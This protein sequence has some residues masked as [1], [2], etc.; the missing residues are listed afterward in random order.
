MRDHEL[1][2]AVVAMEGRFP[3]AN[4][5]AEL[6]QRLVNADDLVDPITP[7]RFLA[8]GGDPALLD[9]PDLVLAEAPITDID[10]FDHRYFGYS[11]G[12]AALIDPQQRLF[13]EVCVHA[14]E[15]AGLDP[16][17][18]PRI[19]V[20]AGSGQGDYLRKVVQP[21]A[22]PEPESTETFTAAISNLISSLP[23]RVAYCL[24]LRG[25]AVAVQTACSTSLV[26][27]HMACQDLLSM[28]C[29]A[30]LAGG[31]NVNP[32]PGLGHVAVPGGLLSPDGRC[33]SFAA[34]ANGIGS[35]DAVAV[36]VLKRYLDAVE[37]GDTI[38]GVIR[39]SAINN[40]GRDK[41]GFT[42]PSVE[43]QAE[44]IRE[45][46]AMADLDAGSI[47]Y[48]EAHGTGTPTG[49][50][51]EVA[52]LE[53]A[54]GPLPAASC[55]IGSIKSNLGHTD[56]AA[57]VVGLIKAV[58]CVEQGLIPATLHFDEPNP[59]IDF[60]KSPLRVVSATEPWTTRVPRRAGVS[61]FG[62][63]GTNAHL[64]VEQP[65]EA[66]PN[67]PA[68]TDQPALLTVTAPNASS[69]QRRCVQLSTHF[70]GRDVD[71]HHAAAALRSGPTHGRHRRSVPIS[72]N[73]DQPLRQLTQPAAPV[74]D[75]DLWCFPGGGT[76]TAG[77]IDG[78][79]CWEAFGSAFDQAVLAAAVHV[80]L[81]E[82]LAR[83]PRN[84]VEASIGIMAT[85]YAV[86][87]LLTDKVGPPRAVLGHSLGE[88]AAALIAGVLDLPSAM[89]MAA[90]RGHVLDAAGGGTTL[91]GAAAAE[92]KSELPPQLCI[93]ADNGPMSS[94]VS[95]PT[96]I[97]EA[98]TRSVESRWLVRR[99]DVPAAVHHPLLDEHM[100]VLAEALAETRLQA[101]T[102]PEF[103]STVHAD[104]VSDVLTDSTYWLAQM[105]RP[106]RL[107]EAISVARSRGWRGGLDIGPGQS[108]V[109]VAESLDMP[110]IP[111]MPRR[112]DTHG[113]AHAVNTALGR[114]WEA[115]AEL[116]LPVMPPLADAPPYPF[117][118]VS[119]W[120]A[121]PQTE[122][123]VIDGLGSGN[124]SARDLA[125][126]GGPLLVASPGDLPAN[127][128][129]DPTDI[130]DPTSADTE[131]DHADS[132]ALDAHLTAFASQEIARTLRAHVPS[133]ADGMAVEALCAHL[134]VRRPYDRLVQALIR[135]LLIHGDLE[136]LNGD[137]IR[138]TEKRPTRVADGLAADLIAHCARVLPDVVSGRSNGPEVLL[139]GP[140]TQFGAEDERTAKMMGRIT[141]KL[142]ATLDDL[143]G[144]AG[145]AGL[146][147]L[148]IGAGRG[149]LSWPA[150]HALKRHPG[151]TF[152]FTDVG[153]SFVV[154]A[155]ERA[156]AEQLDHMQFAT[157]DAGHSATEQGFVS[158]SQDVVIAFNSLHAVPDASEAIRTCSE[159]LA[160][161]GLLFLVE[162]HTLPGHAV[163]TAGLHPGMWH[164]TDDR[165]GE[166]PILPTAR[167]QELLAKAGC[168]ESAVWHTDAHHMLLV[169]RKAPSVEAKNLTALRS[170]C[171]VRVVPVSEL[172]GTSWQPSGPLGGGPA[173]PTSTP[174]PAAPEQ[175]ATTSLN[176]R[177]D[178]SSPYRAPSGELETR[179]AAAWSSLLGIDQVGVDDD[180]FEL[181]GE[182]LLA[183][184]IMA[185]IRSEIGIDLPVRTLFDHPTI[186]TLT[187]ALADAAAGPDTTQKSEPAP[188]VQIRRRERRRG[189]RSHDGA[190]G[191]L[192]SL[193]SDHDR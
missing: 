41:V 168:S 101:P 174:S 81:L 51:I 157:L 30:A 188:A 73:K 7:E 124:A 169:A 192:S 44:V 184:R 74:V 69:L 53:R 190:V 34:G 13:L 95:G 3:H 85:Q 137:Q 107:A 172:T 151:V 61:S 148:E 106:V 127:A 108:L 193:T 78:L 133:I 143:V 99:L 125:R 15:Q 186:A 142:I 19:G 121:A 117:E 187:A 35:G 96:S 93:A 4:S 72:N 134:E 139:S 173:R 183:I 120:S 77:A 37:D 42:A 12:E 68:S 28:R 9:D 84:N 104:V 57:G 83:G 141:E 5:V 33:R 182:S 176:Q 164:F 160:P 90:A 8:A 54:Y 109:S 75:A 170:N 60:A 119:C 126:R 6:W 179:V 88:Y 87:Q 2:I 11:L 29:D 82:V 111:V 23:T 58:L 132:T 181:G 159:L 92:L 21:V 50:P 55:G 110:L 1:D 102:G 39:G 64:I 175:V 66:P 115:G 14:L 49:D 31:S 89:R 65:P 98:W 135:V 27:V 113:A 10:R 171:P 161:G 152:T 94:L 177:G 79:H 145:D 163:L 189:V 123:L 118:P 43:G 48:V 185:H 80:D 59:E 138:L 131:V 97:L 150:A 146:R 162:L 40:D 26:A 130:P 56:T 144:R 86:A 22:R 180:F 46:L 149:T 25:P 191:T 154:E 155:Q 36:V 76:L 178:L 47:G 91:V 112:R 18:Q 122:T 140:T 158:G 70:A 38:R 45:A 71:W 100:H 17:E 105:R 156:R 136:T 63:G 62:I 129:L 167:W 153:R 32:T 166:T 67:E 103:L 24:N 128:T 165:P 114:L 20:Y 116:D 147:I 52:A 16:A